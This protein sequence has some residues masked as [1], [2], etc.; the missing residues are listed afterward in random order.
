MTIVRIDTTK[1]GR[2]GGEARA[3]NLTPK[4][5]KKAAS[6]AAQARWDRYYAEHPEKLK[7]RRSGA[8]RKKKGKGK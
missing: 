5:R 7:T 4:Q 8:S 2:L 6:E 3:R 1:S